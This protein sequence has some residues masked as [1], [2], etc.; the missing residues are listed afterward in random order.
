[1]VSASA[2]IAPEVTWLRGDSLSNTSH[3]RCFN[4]VAIELVSLK[5]QVVPLAFKMSACP[6]L[7]EL[8]YSS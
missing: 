4:Y 5:C 8:H 7:R 6:A 3:A 1:M 2:T